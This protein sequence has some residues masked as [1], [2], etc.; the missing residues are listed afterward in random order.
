MLYTHDIVLLDLYN[1]ELQAG[2]VCSQGS[3]EP[4]SAAK[5]QVAWGFVH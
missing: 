2:M 1:G 3:S 5:V 4:S